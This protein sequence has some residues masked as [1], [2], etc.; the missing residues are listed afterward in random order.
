MHANTVSAALSR[1]GLR[2]VKIQVHFDAG[3]MT[4]KDKNQLIFLK[5]K[6]NKKSGGKG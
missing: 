2:R 4:E 5:Y 3:I 1:V 6:I